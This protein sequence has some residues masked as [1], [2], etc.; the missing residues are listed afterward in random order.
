MVDAV[1]VVKLLGSLM[2]NGGLSSGSGSNVLQSVLGAV[3]G[4]AM[5]QGGGSSALGS[6]LG[7]L[8]GGGGRQQAGGALG[9]VLGG[10][11]GGG[12]APAGGG[13][14]GNVL[15]GLLGGGGAAA[16]G[17][18]LGSLLGAAI[19]QFA[20]AQQGQQTSAADHLPQGMTASQANDQ[21]TVLIR[22]M[23]NAAKADGRVDQQEQ[24]QIV[25]QLGEVTQDEVN[26]IRNEMSQPLDVQG[27]IRSVPKGTEQHVYAVSLMA[28]DLDSNPEAQYL[29]Q[30]AQGLGIS[31][32]ASNQIHQQLGAKLLYG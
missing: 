27:F 5:G 23:I 2:G 16:G 12:G 25:G 20:Q 1:N 3:A 19:G 28:I 11:T 4:G 10:L 6:V 24:E 14:L 18:G 13:G 26:F 21:A 29:H 22:A 32:Q 31:Q 17:G 7:G 30:L 9:S 15:G 8:M